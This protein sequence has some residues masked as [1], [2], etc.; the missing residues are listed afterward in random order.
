MSDKEV[1]EKA[2]DP[3]LR[4]N[5]TDV[6]WN[7]QHENW[8]WLHL[9]SGIERGG[10]SSFALWQAKYM[11]DLGFHFDWSKDMK[12][13]FFYE[14]KVHEKMMALPN[15]SVAILDEGGEM[16]FSR[17]SI[18]RMVIKL[19]Q[20]LMIYGS[21][22]IFLIINIPDWRWLDKYV[23][24]S[25]V[26]SLTTIRTHGKLRRD[27][28]LRRQR[29]FYEAYSRRQVMWA[30]E[31]DYGSLGRPSFYGSFPAFKWYYPTQWGYYS[32]HKTEFLK[33]KSVKKPMKKVESAQVYSA[34]DLALGRNIKF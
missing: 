5:L 26:R 30:S 22:N 4:G 17:K 15:K 25:R 8:D 7:V 16:L 2:L 33:Q 6:A 14:P 27:G 31:T 9:N 10:K 32:H 21:K 18:D 34:G 3:V 20:T 29:G 19:I 28:I 12:H 24:C 23:R 13:V 11:S 1:L